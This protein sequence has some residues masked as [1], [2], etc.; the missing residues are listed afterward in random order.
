MDMRGYKAG[1]SLSRGSGWAA[2]GH[3]RVVHRAALLVV[4]AREWPAAVQQGAAAIDAPQQLH[5]A[6]RLAVERWK[7]DAAPNVA[8]T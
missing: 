2:R 1:E 4:Q 3:D 7:G 6:G 8:R 5:A